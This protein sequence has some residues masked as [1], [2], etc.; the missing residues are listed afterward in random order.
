[1]CVC[2]CRAGNLHFSYLKAEDMQGNKVYKCN[3]LNPYMDLT[4]GGSYTRLH[5]TPCEWLSSIVNKK[6]YFVKRIL[7]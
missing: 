4:S 2:V 7:Q 3:V 6:Q 1:M 5:I